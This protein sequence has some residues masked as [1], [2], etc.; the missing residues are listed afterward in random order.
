MFL[1]NHISSFMLKT[2]ERRQKELVSDIGCG[3]ESLMWTKSKI[4]RPS[5]KIQ[6]DLI[7]VL[8]SAFSTRFRIFSGFFVGPFLTAFA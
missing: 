3:F 2:F 6:R 1:K 4:F 5:R 7:D 8:E